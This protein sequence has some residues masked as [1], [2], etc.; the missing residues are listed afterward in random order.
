MIYVKTALPGCG[1]TKWLLKQAYKALHSS[2]YQTVVYCGDKDKYIKFCEKYVA[3][4]TEVPHIVYLD[5]ETIVQP[6]CILVD[7][8]FSGS[9]GEVGMHLPVAVD[10]F[11]TINGRTTIKNDCVLQQE[12]D[13]VQLSIFDLIPNV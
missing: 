4:F 7:D 2:K 5:S 6:Y 10:S 8:L 3:T 11:I 13:V 12:D 1:K 9:L